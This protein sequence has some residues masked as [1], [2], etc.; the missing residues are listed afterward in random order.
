MGFCVICVRTGRSVKLTP[1][2]FAYFDKRCDSGEC[3]FTHDKFHRMELIENDMVVGTDRGT[4][5]LTISEKNPEIVK[6][7]D[8]SFDAF[9]NQDDNSSLKESRDDLRAKQDDWISDFSI[10]GFSFDIKKD[11][12]SSSGV[13]VESAIEYP[14]FQWDQGFDWD[15]ITDFAVDQSGRLAISHGKKAAVYDRDRNVVWVHWLDMGS[16][17]LDLHFDGGKKHFKSDGQVYVLEWEDGQVAA[18]ARPLSDGY[19]ASSPYENMAAHLANKAPWSLEWDGSTVTIR[20]QNHEVVLEDGKFGFDRIND[21]AAANVTGQESAMLMAATE[22]GL[23]CR[24][25]Q[26]LERKDGLESRAEPLEKLFKFEGTFGNRFDG[27]VALRIS[28][29]Q[30]HPEQEQIVAKIGRGL[31]SLTPRKE[32]IQISKCDDACRELL[33]RYL[34]EKKLLEWD[35]PPYSP[36][37]LPWRKRC[38]KGE[39]EMADIAFDNGRFG[40]D[41]VLQAIASSPPIL[42]TPDG[43]WA[44]GE[45]GKMLHWKIEA[46]PYRFCRKMFRSKFDR[47]RIFFQTEN[48]LYF[49]RKEE[50]SQGKA[51]TELNDEKQRNDLKKEISIL[52]SKDHPEWFFPRERDEGEEDPSTYAFYRFNDERAFR[53]T[54]RDKRFGFDEASDLEWVDGELHLTTEDGVARWKIGE[55]WELEQHI[56]KD[57]NKMS[58]EQF[59]TWSRARLEN[60]RWIGGAWKCGYRTENRDESLKGMRSILQSRWKDEFQNKASTH[61]CRDEQCL[62]G[63]A[64]TW[65]HGAYHPEPDMANVWRR[66]RSTLLDQGYGGL[67]TLNPAS[68]KRAPKILFENNGKTKP[69]TFDEGNFGFNRGRHLAAGANGMMAIH[70]NGLS[71]YNAEGRIA[72]FGLGTNYVEAE[73]KI[74]CEERRFKGLLYRKNR[75][76]GYWG[77]T[78]EGYEKWNDIVGNFE[79]AEVPGDVKDL[80]GNTLLTPY[81]PSRW[82]LRRGDFFRNT[83]KQSAPEDMVPFKIVGGKMDFDIMALDITDGS[84]AAT[85]DGQNAKS[86]DDVPEAVW[87]TTENG[88][89]TALNPESGVILYILSPEKKDDKYRYLYFDDRQFSA[90]KLCAISEAQLGAAKECRILRWENVGFISDGET[91]NEEAGLAYFK[92]FSKTLVEHDSWQME[93][94]PAKRSSLVEDLSIQYFSEGMKVYLPMSI[95][96][97]GGFSADRINAVWRANGSLLAATNEGVRIFSDDRVLWKE[98]RFVPT[99]ETADPKVFDVCMANGVMWYLSKNGNPFFYENGSWTNVE[100]KDSSIPFF[101]PFFSDDDNWIWRLTFNEDVKRYYLDTRSKICMEEATS[102][103]EPPTETKR[104]MSLTLG[105]FMDN[106]VY[107][108]QVIPGRGASPNGLPAPDRYLV[109]SESGLILYDQKGKIER[110]YSYDPDG[111]SFSKVYSFH[112]NEQNIVHLKLE[113]QRTAGGSPEYLKIDGNFKRSKDKKESFRTQTRAKSDWWLKN[114]SEKP[115]DIFAIWKKDE[116]GN[117]SI[118]MYGKKDE[119]KPI[120]SEEQRFVFDEIEKLFFQGDTLWAQTKAGILRYDNR[121]PVKAGL[122][123]TGYDPVTFD[124]EA[125]HW[126]EKDRRS[127]FSDGQ[128]SLVFQNGVFSHFDEDPDGLKEEMIGKMNT[129]QVG[130][131]NWKRINGGYKVAH[132]D[133]ASERSFSNG[134][135]DD[136]K[137][138]H[139]FLHEDR[140]CVKASR[141][142]FYLQ[143]DDFKIDECGDSRPEESSGL[144]EAFPA[145]CLWNLTLPPDRG[146]DYNKQTVLIPEKADIRKIVPI[147]EATLAIGKKY[148]YQKKH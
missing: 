2:L 61:I 110:I 116:G 139:L 51:F 129:R 102:D 44:C 62:S 111:S 148:V 55:S 119:S 41:T 85:E 120:F 21:L 115:S 18:S 74:D 95:D 104:A 59:R 78:D 124:E 57:W 88:N 108:M 1:L 24:E 127:V 46:Q 123:V 113:K 67:W 10:H 11:G 144:E 43:T 94:D 134:R 81:K 117:F 3:E 32:N 75:P 122:P 28:A 112:D 45:D 54:F 107:D 121:N 6:I 13:S 114:T 136:D 47:D 26:A 8:V 146:T 100:S 20:Y 142:Y 103:R 52:T 4:T 31:Y 23:L 79:A 69:V 80:F 30:T 12:V 56:G 64:F 125:Y 29:L 58:A 36:N 137:P 49:F 63:D 98:H 9:F 130:Q 133:V 7:Y 22:D 92:N 16:G 71:T 42:A 27:N 101:Q 68:T 19:G 15:W 89:V 72:L 60:G 126:D 66:H 106:I 37:G 77:L 128:K 87:F 76:K 82:K 118:D 105:N 132:T 48:K 70:E 143:K 138:A 65:K 53:F 145:K 140:I 147:H 17:I 91:R 40:F 90:K 84:L 35:F 33:R 93:I 109:A 34:T 5:H 14:V 83:Q 39:N 38:G 97:S 96:P 73:H 99:K 131:W 25:Y 50:F 86:S 135:F 141:G